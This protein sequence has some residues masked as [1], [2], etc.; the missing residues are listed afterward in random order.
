MVFLKIGKIAPKPKKNFAL[1]EKQSPPKG[2][3]KPKKKKIINSKKIS[4]GGNLQFLEFWPPKNG[5][6]AKTKPGPKKK[7]ASR[8]GGG[9]FNKGLKFFKIP[10]VR[11]N[12]FIN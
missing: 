2:F 1:K 6:N 9:L 11:D 3:G 4:L 7:K 5:G 8:K 10:G 12:G